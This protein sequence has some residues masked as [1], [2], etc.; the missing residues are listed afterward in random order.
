MN[1]LIKKQQR[2][3]YDRDLVPHLPPYKDAG[4][5]GLKLWNPQGK[6]SAFHHASEVFLLKDF[7]L[8]QSPNF[9]KYHICGYDD[10]KNEDG[11]D[12]SNTVQ[13][14]GKLTNFLK[15]IEM[16]KNDKEAAKEHVNYWP[17]YSSFDFCFDKSS[18]ASTASTIDATTTDS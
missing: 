9:S 14:L 5:F 13:N 1:T 18:E 11:Q 15:L 8:S 4:V 16:L 7:Q 17:Q 6:Q 3:V 12:C 2:Y 10:M